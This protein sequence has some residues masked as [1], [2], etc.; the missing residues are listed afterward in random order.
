AHR[1][2]H[3]RGGVTVLPRRRHRAADTV[4]GPDGVRRS[5][6]H[7]GRVV[8]VRRPGR[9]D[10]ARRAGVQPV[11]RLAPGLARPA[12]AAAVTAEGAP[13]VVLEVRD[14]HTQI[15]TRWGVVRAVDGVSLTLREGETLGL[16]GESGSGK[17]MTA[18][19]ILKLL[20][21]P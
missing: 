12:P 8:A 5:R 14:L 19:S 9:R 7:R 2:R 15:H 11:R 16:V 18:L 21:E 17:T 3:R 20:P 1:V 10:H 6:A 13:A 4:L